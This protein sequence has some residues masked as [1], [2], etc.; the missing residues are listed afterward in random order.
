M[1]RSSRPTAHALP[2]L[3]RMH[4]PRRSL[5]PRE[6]VRSRVESCPSLPGV[7]RDSLGELGPTRARPDELGRLG[8]AGVVAD[9]DATEVDQ[10]VLYPTWFAEELSTAYGPDL[11]YAA[12]RA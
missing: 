2:S 12:V 10:T 9:I 1:P 5:L 11:A 7:N 3:R 6:R 8:L 4:R